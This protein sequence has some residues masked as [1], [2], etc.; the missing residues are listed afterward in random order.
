MR[1]LDRQ[2][3]LNRFRVKLLKLLKSND[4]QENWSRWIR[5][6]KWIVE[7]KKNKS[8]LS[9]SADDLF[10]PL[11]LLTSLILGLQGKVGIT[12]AESSP[13]HCG[14]AI[15]KLGLKQDVGISEHAIL[16]R[17]HHKLKEKAE[18]THLKHLLWIQL[19]KWH[20]LC[21]QICSINKSTVARCIRL[22]LPV[23]V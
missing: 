17:H 20:F 16:E 7:N 4:G 13:G 2:K 14:H 11:V 3:F 22:N 12:L 15:D 19:L 5:W 1:E 21:H 6:L 18:L 23:S 10:V 8:D 9:C